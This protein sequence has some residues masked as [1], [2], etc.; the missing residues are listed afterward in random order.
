MIA[1]NSNS[2]CEQAQ[3]YYYDY[4][5]GR[6]QECIPAEILDHIDQCRFC[7]TEVNRL[8]IELSRVEDDAGQS[9]EQKNFVAV[10][11]L[12]LHF[13][14]IGALVTCETVRPFLPS[15]A[16]PTLEVGVPTPI[17]VHLDKCQQCSDDLE[18]IRQLK[19]TYKQL[20]RLGQLF[21]EEPDVNVELCAKAKNVINSVEAMVFKGISAETL[22]HFCV[23]PDCRELFYKYR[24]SRAEKLYWNTEESPMPCDVISA[25]DIFDYVVPYGIDPDKDQYAMF[26]HSLTV[27]LIECRECLEKMQELHKTVYNILQ[28]A[29]SGI[30]TCFKVDDSTR[31]SMVSNH[32]D[33]YKDWPIEVEV[34]GTSRETDMTKARKAGAV[35]LVAAEAKL[36]PKQKRSK[37]NIRPFVKPVAAA[38]AIL[39]AA[40]LLF[41]GPVAKAVDLD[42][43]YEA[44]VRIKNVYVAIYVPEKLE[45][46]QEV[47][48]STA[49]NVKMFKVGKRYVLWDIGSGYTRTKDADTEAIKTTKLNRDASAEVE[50]TMDVPWGL[51]PFNKISAVR[52]ISEDVIW[53]QV[54][55]E[56][57]DTTIPNTEVY[58]LMWTEKAIGG[59][60]IH[61]KWRGY[62]DTKTT[63]PKRIERWQRL[64]R[65]DEYELLIATEVVCPTAVEVQAAIRNVGF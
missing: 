35:G 23:C 19:L 21:A 52:A 24:E 7:Q 61:K 57:I 49:L 25:T 22:R 63:L 48:I 32:D 34:F 13:D 64:P 18:T 37:L 16:D 30:V 58:D 39:I 5:C 15:L 47:W 65:E 6:G 28:R 38:A 50:K 27:H 12:K 42:Q 36:K 54:T 2:M 1:S 11:N 62:I 51:L 40:L 55:D 14:Y 8:K 60:I 3:G 17:T 20:C 26:R 9:T 29:E 41:H 59:S 44:L 10:T 45:P 33:I 4:L 53:Q 56:N 31:D 43:I 46:A